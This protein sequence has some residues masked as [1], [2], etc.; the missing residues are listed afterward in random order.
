MKPILF[1]TID[2]NDIPRTEHAGETGVA[3]WRTIQHDRFR[4]RIVEYSKNYLADHW[5]RSG[6]IVF[7]LEGEMISELSDGSTYKLSAGMS[8][9]VTDGAS[10]HRSISESGVKL[11][12]IDGAFLTNTTSHSA[13]PWK[14]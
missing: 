7:C 1:Y 14:M 10:A 8:Y 6:H 12:I 4:M 2:W 3:Y 5:C 13:N 9:Q 11:L